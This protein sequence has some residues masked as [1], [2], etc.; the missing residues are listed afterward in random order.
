C[1]GDLTDTTGFITS[2]Q[3]NETHNLQCIW[4]ILQQAPSTVRLSFNEFNL[5]Q[6]GSCAF[7]FLEIRS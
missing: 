4:R 2:P 7:D 3:T 6:H 1:G 5:E